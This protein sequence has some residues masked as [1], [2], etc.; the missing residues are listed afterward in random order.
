MTKY[1]KAILYMVISSL[2]LALMGTF[3]KMLVDV[4]SIQK[5]IS[6]TAITA[7]VTFIPYLKLPKSA[8][9]IKEHKWLIIRI[10]GGTIGMVTSFMAYDMLSLSTANIILKFSVIFLLLFSWMFLNEK[11][12]KLHIFAICFGFFG[13]FFIIK[14]TFD[15]NLLGY[16]V[17]MISAFS[18][19]IAYFSLRKLN[20]ATDPKITVFYFAFFSTILTLPLLLTNM[21]PLNTY[22]VIILF[23]TGIF[24]AIG[25]YGLTFAYTYAPASQVSIYSYFTIIFS[26]IFDVFAGRIPDIWN[27]IGYLIIFSSSYIIFK[28]QQEKS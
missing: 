6:R 17:A 9:K 20:E 2:A 3:S 8:R 28:L 16:L 18:A 21:V 14:P 19:A 13:L 27:I 11:M 15:T 26:A 25:Q 5:S 22:Q 10:L 12:T 4:P 23:L 24:G 7:L 1:K